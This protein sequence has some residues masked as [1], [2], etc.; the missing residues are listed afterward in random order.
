[1]TEKERYK[2]FVD[3]K[4]IVFLKKER[5]DEPTIKYKELPHSPDDLKVLMKDVSLEAPLV[6]HCKNPEEAFNE[7]FE[8]Y[9]KITA[10]GGIVRRKKKYMVIKR[11]GLWDI[12]K[13]KVEKGEDIETGAIR[14]I[15][16]ECGIDGPTIDKFLTS[17]FHIFKYKGKRAI[18]KT[19]WYTMNYE[20]SKETTPEEKEG[21]TK[22]KWMTLEEMLDIRGKTYG[23]INELLD[24]FEASLND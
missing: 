16:E 17:T 1:M 24:V 3:H 13:G 18:K 19:Y 10:A 14:E 2:V 7:Y 4:P 11:N 6:V 12:P 8:P 15:E 22:A 21:I 23:S 20:G 9:K 5:G